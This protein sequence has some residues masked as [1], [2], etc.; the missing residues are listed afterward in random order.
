MKK[1]LTRLGI[2]LAGLIGL[3]VVV[4]IAVWMMSSVRMNKTYTIESTSLTIPS[5]A[6]A[7]AEGKRQFA[8]RGCADCHGEDGAGSL[9]LDDPWVGTV[10]GSNLT[11]GTGGKAKQYDEAAWNRAIR[12]GVSPTGKPLIIW[13]KRPAVAVISTLRVT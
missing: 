9:V 6:A 4:V 5:D 10:N 7:I 1:V 11:S 8:T 12:H 3:L 13:M 2:I